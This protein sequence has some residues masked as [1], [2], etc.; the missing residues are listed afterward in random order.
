MAALPSRF[1]NWHTI[2]MR[3]RRWAEAGVLDRIFTALQEHRLI[4]VKVE[5]AS[6]GS[7]SVKVHPDGMGA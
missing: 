5:R 1:G 4:R 2:Y 3:M 7:T 6:L